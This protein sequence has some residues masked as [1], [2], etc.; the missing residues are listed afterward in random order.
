MA[1][2]ISKYKFDFLPRF[3][4]VTTPHILEFSAGFLCFRL[5]FTLWGEK[6]RQFNE[7]NRLGKFD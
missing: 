7:N 5:N 2:E 3:T 4:A 1:G 6:M